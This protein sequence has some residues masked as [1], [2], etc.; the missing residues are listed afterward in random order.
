MAAHERFC[1]CPV[2]G[3][4]SKIVARSDP[5]L[6]RVHMVCGR[7]SGLQ[8]IEPNSYSPCAAR[9]REATRS[10][11]RYRRSDTHRPNRRQWIAVLGGNRHKI[12]IE[13]K[14]PAAPYMQREGATLLDI[15]RDDRKHP[16]NRR[17]KGHDWRK[18]AWA[19]KKSL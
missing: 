16:P 10:G 14:I 2:R 17:R 8:G 9:L 1:A 4:H 7:R 19:L 18:Q 15:L 13:V 12:L 6:H 11:S 3:C 5:E